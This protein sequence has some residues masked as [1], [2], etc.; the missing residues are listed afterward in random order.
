VTTATGT[1][2]SPLLGKLAPELDRIEPRTRVAVTGLHEAKFREL[3]PDGGWSVAQ[4][5][6]HLCRSNLG[7]LDGPLTEAVTKTV[8]RGPSDR[9]WRP[10][11]IG[12]WL[13]QSL[14]EGTKPLPSP[15]LFRVESESRANVVD[16]FL[17]TLRR[18][19][20]LMQQADGH[21]LRIM[22]ASPASPLFRLNLGDAF[23]VIVVH[24]HRHLAQAERTRRA[25][26]M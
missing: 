25:V 2:K 14:V 9:E 21:D 18:T 6:E 4:V 20:E 13:A 10:S 11:L 24:A 12:G 17:A 19:R 15:K 23:R 26:G 8:A 1:W 5:F 16:E 3:P 22:F 7:Y